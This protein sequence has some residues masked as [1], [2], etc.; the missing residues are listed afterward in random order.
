MSLINLNLKA[1]KK[2]YHYS[3]NNILTNKLNSLKPL[4]VCSFGD[5]HF[6]LTRRKHL[7]YYNNFKYSFEKIPTKEKIFTIACVSYLCSDIF[8]I[9]IKGN[10][11]GCD[12]YPWSI[13]DIK[14]I[15]ILKLYEP[16]IKD[17][18]VITGYYI[19]E[20]IRKDKIEK[21]E[22]KFSGSPKKFYEI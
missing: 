18:F 9:D 2:I 12:N 10:L 7:F 20:H 5:K 8:F 17:K 11:F 4:D 22:F 16:K 6:I 19:L 14:L 3:F 13:K 1:K 21:Y 15:K